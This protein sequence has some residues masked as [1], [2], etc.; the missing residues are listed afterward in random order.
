M[1][2]LAWIVIALD[3]LLGLATIVLLPKW[4]PNGSGGFALHQASTL[5]LVVLA[6]LTSVVAVSSIRLVRLRP[7]RSTRMNA[8]AFFLA[9][10]CL[11]AADY[12]AAE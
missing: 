8:V 9:F 10:L 6:A 12:F 2:L 1:R 11:A 4:E 3:V 5:T 7:F